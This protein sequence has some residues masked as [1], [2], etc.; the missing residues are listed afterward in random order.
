MP[1]RPALLTTAEAAERLGLTP[2][3]VRQLARDGALKGQHYGRDWLF[4]ER[5]VARFTPPAKGRPRKEKL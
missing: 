1:K 4:D 3:R 5:D 2:G